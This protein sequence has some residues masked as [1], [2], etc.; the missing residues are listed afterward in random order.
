MTTTLRGTP[1]PGPDPDAAAGA[2]L[3]RA[4]EVVEGELLRE[5]Q[6]AV[7]E[8]RRGVRRWVPARVVMLVVQV[9]R[10]RPG[11]LVWRAVLGATGVL[12]VIC[13]GFGSWGRRAWDA[14]TL[15]AYRRQI[16]AAE[17]L[18][19]RAL[20]AEWTARREQATQ[21][22][23][24]RLLELPALATGLV[25][26][27]AGAV[28]GLVVA[29][30]VLGLL[31]WLAGAGSVLAPVLAA[32][33]VASWAF[34]LIALVWAPAVA[35]IPV[36]VLVA[37]WREGR[38]RGRPPSWAL[39]AKRGEDEGVVLTPMG[40]AQALAHLGIGALNK[41]MKEGWTVAFITP[42]TRV[43]N[44]GYHAV[45]SL[46]MGV[47]PN[48]IADKGDVLARN[49]H[50]APLETWPS[51]ADQ[52]GYVDL[53]VADPGA[54]EKPAPA[55]PLLYAG[56]CDVFAGVPLGV[57]QRG[58]VIA[59]P[60]VQN[61]MVFGGL[62][63]QGKSNAARVTI[64]GAALDPLPEIWVFVFAS[65]G[66]FDAYK[67]RL[68][69]YEKFGE[70]NEDSVCAAALAS[71]EELYAEVGRR[72]GRLAEL[73]AKKVTRTIAEKHPDLRPKVALFS[74]C[75]ELFG[76]EQFGKLTAEVATKT[77]RRARKTGITLLFDTQSSRADAIPPKIVELVA[78]NACFAVKTWRSNDGFLGDG[79]FQ[80][81]IR[82]T[83]LR[84]G[85]DQGTCVLTG[86][87]I[88]RFEIL[89]WFYIEANDDTGYDAATEVIARAMDTVHPA[90]PVLGERLAVPA[91]P[92]T[93]DL[94]TDLAHVLGTD[95]LPVADIPPLLTRLA[96]HWA[97]Y[98]RMTGKS[99][100]EALAQQGVKVPTTGNRYPLDPSAV[101]EALARRAAA[102]RDDS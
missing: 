22:R 29:L 83:E 7:L 71:L 81:G 68:A 73:G 50:R 31:V 98:R 26:L 93:R 100:R 18:G 38:R 61:N 17:A 55:Y 20:L 39:S 21:A 101:R 64:L 19:D 94:L 88:E 6:A 2:G 86:A 40:I 75:H 59:P 53:W 9:S 11:A 4:P 79:S 70:G 92:Q 60:L 30:L 42:P 56:V 36:W 57:S 54:T 63:G 14:G 16:T 90:V 51:A 96:P 78:I 28:V 41:A 91:V 95:P 74:E 25:S 97:P 69:R 33:T 37:A 82:A 76:H 80:A 87:S 46:P 5:G 62:M 13:Q 72:E 32:L 67:P 48:M 27:A 89:K 49:L 85:K 52:P 47:T 65:N 77:L 43:N 84:P 35:S 58:D 3:E 102:E 66:D 12:H 34:T 15:G 99:L 24:Q 10:S 8:W 45:F 44:R 1:D 23:H